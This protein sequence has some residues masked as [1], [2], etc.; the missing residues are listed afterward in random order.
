MVYLHLH[1][2]KKADK[3]WSEKQDNL[4]I[5]YKPYEG[6]LSCHKGYDGNAWKEEDLFHLRNQ[7]TVYKTI[8]FLI[9]FGITEKKM[10]KNL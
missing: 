8:M 9:R 10:K 5:R 3:R 6:I 2:S 1:R 7:C 4:R